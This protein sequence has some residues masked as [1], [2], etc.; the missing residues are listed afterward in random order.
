MARNTSLSLRNAVI[1]QIFTRN[2]KGGTFQ[3]VEADLDRIQALGADIIYLLPVQPSGEV[4]RKGSMGSPYA[5]R[6]YRIPDPVQ[7]TME[8]FKALSSAIH[9]RGMKLMIDVVY[10]HTSPDSWLA[11]NHPEWFFHKADGSLGNRIGD[12]WDV[13][14]LDYTKKDLWR[15]QIDTLKMWAEYVDGFRCDVAPMVPLDFWLEARAKVEEVRPDCIWLA[16]SV[17]P[18]FIAMNRRAGIETL[19]D[20]ELY[21][22]FDICYDYDLYDSMKNAMTGKGSLS[23]YLARM[24]RQETMYPSNYCKLRCLENHDRNRAAAMLPEERVLRNWTAWT[25]F[26]KGT[27]MIYAGEEFENTH[28]PTLFEHDPVNFET[29]RDLSPLMRSLSRIKKNPLFRNT[30]M[31]A[32]AIGSSDDVILAVQE[33]NETA[34]PAQEGVPKKAVGI[35]SSSGRPQVLSVDLPDGTYT[36]AIDGSTVEVFEKL[37]SFRGEPVILL[38]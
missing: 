4:H 20:S 22:A 12:W 19:S 2:Y 36:N 33:A 37:L 14:D 32:E 8:D 21:Q 15:Y 23:H 11:E 13:V 10:N 30:S 31:H 16:E 25:F 7:G 26:A 6:D 28:H 29:G 9:A 18:A 27:A 24:D 34:A 35:F 5:I 38:L 1:Y 3:A 17:E